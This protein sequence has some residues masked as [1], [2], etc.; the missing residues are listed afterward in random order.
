MRIVRSISCFSAAAAPAPAEFEVEFVPEGEVIGGYEETRIE[1]T[2]FRTH[3]VI[4][5]SAFIPSQNRL[6]DVW[7]RKTSIRPTTMDNEGIYLCI[8]IDISCG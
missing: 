2:R 7:F 1:R 5:A 8:S 3:V 4:R 6:Y